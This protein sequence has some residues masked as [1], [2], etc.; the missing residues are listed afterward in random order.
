[1]H[2]AK[3]LKQWLRSRSSIAGSTVRATTLKRSSARSRLACATP[4]E[5]DAIRSDFLDA[6]HDAVQP[7]HAT[8]WI[9][10]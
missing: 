7:A 6:V 8:V 9:R 3:Q 5:L 1:M 10:Q 2:A 4:S